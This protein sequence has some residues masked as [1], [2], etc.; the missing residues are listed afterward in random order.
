MEPCKTASLSDVRAVYGGPEGKLWEL[1]MGEQ[2]HIG[3]LTSSRDLAQKAGIQPGTCGVDF[4]CC[5]GAGMRFLVRFCGAAAMTGVDATAAMVELG[6]KRCQNEGFS[7][8]I[9]FVLADVCEN[10]LEAG[11]AD[12]VWGEDAWC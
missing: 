3:G 1:L 7:D 12:F 10:G 8:K 11:S 2:I 5:S 4:C 9:R 6:K